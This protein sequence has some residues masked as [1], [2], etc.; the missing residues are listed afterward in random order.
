MQRQFDEMKNEIQFLK[1]GT[2]IV[3]KDMDCSIRRS[4][5]APAARFN[6]HQ[7]PRTLPIPMQQEIERQVEAPMWIYID[8]HM[9]EHS[10]L[11]PK[12]SMY[13]GQNGS[14]V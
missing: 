2:V 11:V 9:K 12:H 4:S 10:V 6:D 7:M 13:F 8:Q 14:L 3:L 5:R 1:V